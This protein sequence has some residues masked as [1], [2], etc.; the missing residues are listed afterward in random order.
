MIGSALDPLAS[1]S[2]PGQP[3]SSPPA[4]QPWW[5]QGEKPW[6]LLAACMEL[7]RA[8]ASGQPETYLSNL[9]VHQ[10]SGWREEARRGTE[11]RVRYI[12]G[13]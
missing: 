6:Q 9:P 8:I 4:A 13:S 2:A 10:V 1:E 12:S 7:Q 11:Q 3:P 5:S